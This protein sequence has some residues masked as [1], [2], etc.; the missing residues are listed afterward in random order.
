[1]LVRENASS[2][3]AGAHRRARSLQTE[4]AA[5]HSSVVRREAPAV[6][7]LHTSKAHA[8]AQP[9]Q[10]LVR[11]NPPATRVHCSTANPR[12]TVYHLKGHQNRLADC[13]KGYTVFMPFQMI[14]GSSEPNA[15]AL[16]P[17]R[18]TPATKGNRGCYAR[19]RLG[20]VQS[21]RAWVHAQPGFPPPVGRP[22]RQTLHLLTEG[23]SVLAVAAVV[24][25]L[26]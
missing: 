17:H 12:R 11:V 23:A 9:P 25:G 26:R 24:R 22:L 1:L 8:E 7:H 5:L 20:G 6:Q 10:L 3:G 21:W 16:H 13:A 14:N 4:R 2:R 15:P 19:P 18:T